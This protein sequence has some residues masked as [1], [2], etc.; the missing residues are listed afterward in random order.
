MVSRLRRAFDETLTQI[1]Y[2]LIVT[3]LAAGL[4]FVFG[5]MA[6]SLLEPIFELQQYLIR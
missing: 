5:L 2:C 3:G 6:F 4:L 1:A